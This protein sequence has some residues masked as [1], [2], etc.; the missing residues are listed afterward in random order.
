MSSEDYK[1]LDKIKKFN[2]SFDMAS[3]T[4]SELQQQRDT[5]KERIDK[6]VNHFTIDD[7]PILSYILHVT[8]SR[9]ELKKLAKA[10]DRLADLVEINTSLN[11]KLKVIEAA[12]TDPN[13]F[14]LAFG[15]F[16]QEID[17]DLEKFFTQE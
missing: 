6:I 10:I 13:W 3:K 1:K 14:A 11:N 7:V 4:K 5:V 9:V 8:S 17:S 16:D 2:F 12:E 15:D